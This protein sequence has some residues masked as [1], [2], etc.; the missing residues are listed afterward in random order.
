MDI[1]PRTN[2]KA[3]VNYHVKTYLDIS[4]RHLFF[5]LEHVL[6]Q[7]ELKVK[8]NKIECIEFQYK[9]E[10]KRSL[11]YLYNILY[12]WHGPILC[13]RFLKW[14]WPKTAPQKY[15]IQITRAYIYFWKHNYHD[16][17]VTYSVIILHIF[18]QMNNQHRVITSGSEQ[19]I[20]K[21][22]FKIK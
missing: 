1:I 16:H 10:R 12:I 20:C 19:T 4:W 11:T 2:G 5:L 21:K 18:F 17:E 3:W 22:V 13:F 8:R 15:I 9:T 7:S 6:N 14:L